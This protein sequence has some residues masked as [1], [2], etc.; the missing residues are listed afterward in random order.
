MKVLASK[1]ILA[2]SCSLSY[3]GG[4]GDGLYITMWGKIISGLLVRK[5]ERMIFDACIGRLESRTYFL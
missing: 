2:T 1:Q 3:K 5:M 4:I